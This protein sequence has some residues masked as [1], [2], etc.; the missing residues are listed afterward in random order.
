MVLAR[1]WS[2]R[3]RRGAAAMVGMAAGIQ[4]LVIGILL[5]WFGLEN[6]VVALNNDLLLLP[7]GG[8]DTEGIISLLGMHEGLSAWVL[9]IAGLVL[10][11][12]LLVFLFNRKRAILSETVRKA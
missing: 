2:H 11:I 8:A 6:S 5:Q 7:G 12:S 3:N 4:M 1:K 9:G 10:G